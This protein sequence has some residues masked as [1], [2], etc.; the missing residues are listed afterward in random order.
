MSLLLASV[1]GIDIGS[2]VPI[3]KGFGCYHPPT[4]SVM[5]RDENGPGPVPGHE[6]A[7]HLEQ[8]APLDGVVFEV[9]AQSIIGQNYE[10]EYRSLLSTFLPICTLSIGTQR[11]II[12]SLKQCEL[13]Y[14]ELSGAL[15]AS[16]LCAKRVPK[17]PLSCHEA[18]HPVLRHQG[19]AQRVLAFM[20]QHERGSLPAHLLDGVRLLVL[21]DGRLATFGHTLVF[22]HEYTKLWPQ[23]SG[24]FAAPFVSCGLRR[25]TLQDLCSDLRNIFSRE[26]LA[27]LST[28]G[29]LSATHGNS[30]YLWLAAALNFIDSHSAEEQLHLLQHGM[31]LPLV[32]TE[33]GRVL[34]LSQ[35]HR[36]VDLSKWGAWST[37]LRPLLEAASCEIFSAQLPLVH[38]VSHLLCTDSVSLCRALAS[39]QSYIEQMSSSAK[40]ELLQM[41][42]SQPIIP[43]ELRA[44]PLFETLRGTFA[45]IDDGSAWTALQE[46]LP[47]YLPL[48]LLSSAPVL[49][50]KEAFTYKPGT[51][52]NSVFRFFPYVAVRVPHSTVNWSLSLQVRNP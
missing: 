19:N 46:P 28:L 37:V 1:G 42:C 39:R 45:A 35:A 52:P 26:D 24:R 17:V 33:S 20:T 10:R 21:A 29:S 23:S 31:E 44:L 43:K 40:E 34:P 49:K 48:K 6:G 8:I 7:V 32:L 38:A 3:E 5:Q 36:V 47:D 13:E 15:V 16:A 2:L 11:S 12:E 22:A 41:F 18:E 25:F 9:M 14:T 51:R 30:T 50:H 4:G 27:T